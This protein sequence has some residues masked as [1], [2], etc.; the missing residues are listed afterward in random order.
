M[1]C[2]G[3]LSYGHQRE[4]DAFLLRHGFSKVNLSRDQGESTY[5]VVR[6]EAVYPIEV[7]KELGDEKM[8]QWLLEASAREAGN[9]E[10]ERPVSRRRGYAFT[11][12]DT[13]GCP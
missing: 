12:L 2:N 6:M 4:V 9:A 8:I 11:G 1:A 7:A 5:R 3:E 13:T 10:V